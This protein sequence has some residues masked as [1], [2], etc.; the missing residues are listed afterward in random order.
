MGRTPT[1]TCFFFG[2]RGEVTIFKEK[3]NYLA[4]W[5]EGLYRF[6][7][8]SNIFQGDNSHITSCCYY[9][10]VQLYPDDDIYRRVRISSRRFHDKVWQYS[11]AQQ[12]LARAGWM[13]VSEAQRLE[14]IEYRQSFQDYVLPKN[15]ILPHVL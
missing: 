8:S 9:S 12:F 14:A 7:L 13:E 10:N 15:F 4:T 6:N 1:K 3:R 5:S 11:D 2:K